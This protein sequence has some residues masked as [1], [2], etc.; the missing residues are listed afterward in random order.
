MA[1]CVEYDL[2]KAKKRI[3]DRSGRG[4]PQSWGMGRTYSTP[5]QSRSL[6]SVAILL[7]TRRSVGSA[8]GR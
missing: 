6:I 8:T 3:V 2:P 1:I 4:V 5:E 7:S